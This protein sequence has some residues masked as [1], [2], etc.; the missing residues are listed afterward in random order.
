[1]ILLDGK[2]VSLK[3]LD[4]IKKEIEKSNITPH[5]VAILVG[6]NPASKIYVNNKKKAAE[7]VGIISTIIYLSLC[8]FIST[9]IYVYLG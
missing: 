3:I 9:S 5:I 2:A 6:D 7:K 1:M 8:K 4:N